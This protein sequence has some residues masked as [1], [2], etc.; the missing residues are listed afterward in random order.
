VFV[1]VLLVIGMTIALTRRQFF[2]TIG[3]LEQSEAVLA[4]RA[5]EL[6]L[7]MS[8]LEDGVAII[9]EGGNGILPLFNFSGIFKRMENPVAQ[10]AG[11]HGRCGAVERAEECH[12]ASGAGLHQLEVALRGGIENEKFAAT[13]GVELFQVAC[14][15]AHLAGNVMQQRT[16]GARS[17]WEIDA[18]ES[19]EGVNLE[20]SAQQFAGRLELENIAIHRRMGSHLLEGIRLMVRYENF[21]RRDA[22]EFIEDSRERVEFGEAELAG[23]EVAVG[24][25]MDV[26]AFV[27]G[28]EEIGFSV[29]ETEVVECSGT[30]NL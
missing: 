8:H 22:G 27:E 20:M 10:E 4:L 11:A 18:T 26:A 13:V 23:A 25:S 28:G 14:W 15:P 1:V 30:E 19:I 3:R 7:V 5:N 2:D 29:I 21:C 24:E 9:E 17:R 6:D 12:S 16:G